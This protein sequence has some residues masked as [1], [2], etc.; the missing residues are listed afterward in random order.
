MTILLAALV[1]CATVNNGNPTEQGGPKDIS[2]GDL[3]ASEAGSGG[4]GGGADDTD[5][6]GGDSGS[7][8]TGSW[9]TGSWDTG[10]GGGG[11]G[12]TS[13]ELYGSLE[14]LIGT[15]P[16]NGELDVTWRSGTFNGAG[17]C[18]DD[19]GNEWSVDVMGS[20]DGTDA[21]GDVTVTLPGVDCI[22]SYDGM[23]YG[24]LDEGGSLY[25]SFILSGCDGVDYDSSAVVNF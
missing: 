6:S 17:F 1:G 22:S 2:F 5:G 19:E 9:D 3:F 18:S 7:W 15:L 11:G 20:V 24:T 14:V 4:S 12:A 13:G 16:C 25:M 23:V 21:V 8:D 10:G